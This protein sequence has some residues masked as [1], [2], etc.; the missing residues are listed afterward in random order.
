MVEQA[1]H[2]MFNGYIGIPHFIC[3]L[4]GIRQ[5]HVHILC[6]VNGICFSA[7][8]RYGRQLVDLLFQIPNG[9]FLGNADFFKQ[10]RNQA[11]LL[12]QQCT[13]QVHLL[14]HLV[15]VRNRHIICTLNGFQRFFCQF[16]CIHD[17]FLLVSK[18]TP[19]FCNRSSNRISLFWLCGCKL[20]L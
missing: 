9:S 5:N 13:Q 10:L 15:L 17:S 6:D 3:L 1:Q 16:L 12:L 19:I 11:V 2:Q 4:F 8:A 7:A 18:R 20:F 14:N